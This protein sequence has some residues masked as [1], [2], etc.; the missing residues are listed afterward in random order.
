[1][2][3]GSEIVTAAVRVRPAR[4][5]PDHRRWCSKRLG[6]HSDPRSRTGVHSFWALRNL[7]GGGVGPQV[8]TLYYNR[9]GLGKNKGAVALVY[10]KLLK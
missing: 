2:G 1:M 9:A 8:E 5:Q 10:S 4:Q 3:G 6:E 7:G